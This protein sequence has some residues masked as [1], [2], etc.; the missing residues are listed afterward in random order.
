MTT[1]TTYGTTV[2]SPGYSEV[3]QERQDEIYI[4]AV[5]LAEHA[6]VLYFALPTV[7]Q[8]A[9]KHAAT[10]VIGELHGEYLLPAGTS[11][12]DVKELESKVEALETQLSGARGALDELQLFTPAGHPNWTT[13]AVEV[14]EKLHTLLKDQS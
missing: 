6:G 2:L 8:N 9:Y 10:A 12:A 4:A 5:A 13:A 1:T 14:I 11:V 3:R 7:E